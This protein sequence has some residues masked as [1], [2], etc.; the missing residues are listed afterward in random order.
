MALAN[1]TNFMA[2]GCAFDDQHSKRANR[3]TAIKSDRVDIVSNSTDRSR[4]WQTSASQASSHAAGKKPWKCDVGISQ[5]TF[6]RPSSNFGG[7]VPPTA[8]K[9]ERGSLGARRSVF[10]RNTANNGRM[11]SIACGAKLLKTSPNTAIDCLSFARNNADNNDPNKLTQPQR[12]SSEHCEEGSPS[13]TCIAVLSELILT[14]LPAPSRKG[15]N[16]GWTILDTAEAN[17]VALSEKT[18]RKIIE[19]R[20]PV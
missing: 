4:Q 12:K 9:P 3:I 19:Y 15:A 17:I 11:M 16:F 5:G 8:R 7:G 10:L 18:D 13:S 6:N 14:D 2:T 20:L 1:A